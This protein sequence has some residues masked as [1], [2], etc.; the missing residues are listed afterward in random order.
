MSTSHIPSDFKSTRFPEA[1]TYNEPIKKLMNLT[2]VHLIWDEKKTEI[3]IN[4]G[5]FRPP[6][7]S[8][9]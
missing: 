9:L 5:L 1:E 3:L 7:F 4:V 8:V 2:A 6:I